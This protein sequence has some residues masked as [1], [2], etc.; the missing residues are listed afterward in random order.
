M[1]IALRLST[2]AAVTAAAFALAAPAVA[3]YDSPT[4][5]VDNPSER[6]SGGG[7]VTVRLNVARGDDPTFR[8]SIYIPQGYTGNLTPAAGTEIGTVSARAQSLASADIV[9]PL[10]GVLRTDAPTNYRAS[11]A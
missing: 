10:T 5:R 11:A 4:L 8:F 9:V 2:V 3:A 6:I 1:R 7:T